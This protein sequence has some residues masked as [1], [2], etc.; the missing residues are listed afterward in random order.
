MILLLYKEREVIRM[1]KTLVFDM[2]G[3]LCGEVYPTYFEY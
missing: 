1:N 2:D 3:T